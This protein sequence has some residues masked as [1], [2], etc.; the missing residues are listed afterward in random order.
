MI[1]VSQEIIMSWTWCPLCLSRARFL[2]TSITFTTWSGAA[3]Q[4]PYIVQPSPAACGC[5]HTQELNWNR[6][7]FFQYIARMKCSAGREFPG[8]WYIKDNHCEQSS[9]WR[10][11]DW[12]S[13]VGAEYSSSSSFSNS[14]PLFFWRPYTVFLWLSA[15]VF[16][17]FFFFFFF[18]EKSILPI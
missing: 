17:C 11:I 8:Q 16:F 3:W 15:V 2:A 4:Q 1:C 14:T 9:L 10:R 18:Q 13:L 7:T 6:A 12:V 5:E